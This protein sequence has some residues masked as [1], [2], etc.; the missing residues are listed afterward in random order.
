MP[1][2]KV[3]LDPYADIIREQWHQGSTVNSILDAVNAARGRAGLQGVSKRHLETWLHD[4][5]LVGGRQPA[6]IEVTPRLLD[7]LRVFFFDY[8]FDDKLVRH[9]LEQEGYTISPNQLAVLRRKHGMKKRLRTAEERQRA[10]TLTRQFLEGSLESTAA[11]QSLGRGYLHNYIR[12]RARV[13]I[14]QHEAYKIY[15]T[16]RPDD[17]QRRLEMG[18]THRTRFAVPGPNF[19]WCLDGYDRLEGFGFQIHACIDAYSRYIVWI[20]VGRR[21]TASMGV[22]VQYLRTVRNA[23]FRPLFTRTEVGGVMPLVAAAQYRLAE[24]AQTRVPYVN[25]EGETVVLQQ[26]GQIKSCHFSGPSIGNGRIDSWW[27]QLRQGFSDRWIVGSAFLDLHTDTN[28]NVG[29]L[30]RPRPVCALL[31]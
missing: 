3:D 15:R 2:P 31:S 11:I 5:D 8:G 26:G 1:R 27:R 21:S 10:Q 22:M 6:P 29:I 28:R 30:S 14:S 13:A 17:V 12:S 18:W 16:M 19:V 23:G 9:Y 4:H 25:T 24:A 7:Y 20:H